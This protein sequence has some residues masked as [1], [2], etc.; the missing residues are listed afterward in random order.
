MKTENVYHLQCTLLRQNL[1][2]SAVILPLKKTLC[3]DIALSGFKRGSKALVTVE[4]VSCYFC[5]IFFAF[6]LYM[7]VYDDF[8]FL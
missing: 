2:S 5:I 1:E 8:I 3:Q 4:V 7:I 6:S